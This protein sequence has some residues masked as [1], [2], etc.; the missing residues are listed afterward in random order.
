MD[1]LDWLDDSSRNRA[2]E[3][4]NGLQVNLAYP[5]F[6]L[7]DAQLDKTYEK[8]NIDIDQDT[9]FGK[10]FKRFLIT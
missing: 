5:D 9:Y 8:L 6:I 2:Y 10:P 1:E 3:K 4:I 7:D